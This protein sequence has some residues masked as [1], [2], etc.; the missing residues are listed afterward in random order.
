MPR[1]A[2]RLKFLENSRYVIIAYCRPYKIY[3]L[4]RTFDWALQIG[5][6][7]CAFENISYIPDNFFLFWYVLIR[8]AFGS[9]VAIFQSPS[10]RVVGM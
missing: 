1:V 3:E 2:T 4:R 7:K 8:G 10:A 6:H 5:L 9:G